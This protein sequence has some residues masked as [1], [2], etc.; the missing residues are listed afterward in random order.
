VLT[1]AHCVYDVEHHAWV[2]NVKFFPG[3]DG[4]NIPSATI[5]TLVCM[6]FPA[7]LVRPREP[8]TCNT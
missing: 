5:L 2:K 4:E 3:N 6:R 8:T 7:S 1:A